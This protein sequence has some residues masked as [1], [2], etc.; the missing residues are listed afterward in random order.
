MLTTQFDKVELKP[1]PWQVL[2]GQ[3]VIL[4]PTSTMA[5]E[6][7]DLGSMVWESLQNQESF[8]QFL[9]KALD[10]FAVDESTLITDVDEFLFELRN[11][12]LLELSN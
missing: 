4:N 9:S 3:V 6:F 10:E 8:E 7:N 11:D 2:D 12:G 5:Y 1:V